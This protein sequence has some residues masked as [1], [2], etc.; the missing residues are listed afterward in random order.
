MLRF[1]WETYIEHHNTMMPSQQKDDVHKEEKGESPATP[2]VTVND[3][4]ELTDT[5][6][7]RQHQ[8]QLH[9][10][11]EHTLAEDTEKKD[12]IARDKEEAKKKRVEA[13]AKKQLEE[14]GACILTGD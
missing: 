9:R 7:S 12:R 11:K 1:M 3:D 4:G 6:R 2:P 10:E 8:E 14:D 13:T 5:E